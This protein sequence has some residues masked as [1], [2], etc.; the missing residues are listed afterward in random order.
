MY[1]DAWPMFDEDLA[2]F[3]PKYYIQ[4]TRT[5]SRY[6]LK[7]SYL[8]YGLSLGDLRVAVGY[9]NEKLD[10]DIKWTKSGKNK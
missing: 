10:L 2:V 9:K 3:G 6:C 4:P 1:A 5:V 7:F 8:I